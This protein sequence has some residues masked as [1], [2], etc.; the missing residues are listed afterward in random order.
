MAI[1]TGI[2]L[3]LSAGDIVFDETGSLQPISGVPAVLQDLTARVLTPLGSDPFDTT[4]GF[5][6]VSVFAQPANVRTTQDL[7]RLNLVRTLGTDR[8]VSEIHD[9]QIT[10]SDRRSWNVAVD[11]RL[12]D[13][14]AQN[15][16][17]TLGP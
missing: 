17:L 14:T 5:D 3:L 12:T 9:V 16:P 15:V 8:R 1:T 10:S 7:I 2:G 11:L 13:G 4:Y 6:A